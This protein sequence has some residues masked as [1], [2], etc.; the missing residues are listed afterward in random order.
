MDMQAVVNA[1]SR[2]MPSVLRWS[3]AVAKRLRQFDIGVDGKS[4]G[5]SNT[6]ALTLADLSVHELIVAALRDG[7]PILRQ[8]RIEGEESTGD[9]ALF[10][11][12]SECAISIYPIDG[13]KQYR[14]HTGDGWAVMIH[15]QT[16]D[17]VLYSL[18][19][20]PET[21]AQGTWIAWLCRPCHKQIHSLFDEKQLEQ[22]LNTIGSWTSPS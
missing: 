20:V 11:R 9:V 16:P 3:G 18:V 19:Y 21:G 14:D 2:E 17:D 5:S 12:D 15:L 10:S 13:T 22:S 4:S 8:C 7:D 6:D 1:L